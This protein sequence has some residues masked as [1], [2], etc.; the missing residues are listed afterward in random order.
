[1]GNLL[2]AKGNMSGAIHHYQ[3]ALAQQ[4]SHS[5]AYS[6]LRIINCYQKYH[7]ASQSSVPPPPKE[8]AA[9]PQP[10]VPG[11]GGRPAY[12]NADPET[13]FICSH[14]CFTSY[15]HLIYTGL[16]YISHLYWFVVYLPL[17]LVCCISLTYTGLLYI[18]HLYWFVVY[19]S[20]SYWF[21]VYI[22]YSIVCYWWL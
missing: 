16:L 8:S 11:S 12:T 22:S 15:T 10:C 6:S 9:G 5:A 7:R 17:I 19:I 13:H 4:P 21:V 2:A 14:V 3:L 1:M 18:S 20:H